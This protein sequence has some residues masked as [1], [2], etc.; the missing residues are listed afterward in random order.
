MKILVVDQGMVLCAERALYRALHQMEN[1]SVTLIAPALWKEEFGILR[2]EI[3]SSCMP[4]IASKTLFTGKSHRAIYLALPRALKEN[5][6]HILFINAEPESYLAW[7]AVVL[8]N[9]I[10]PRT[11]I[12]FVSWRNIDYRN[13]RFPYELPWFNVHAERTVLAHADH[14]VA[15]NE[16]GRGIFQ[17]KG[18]YGVT[19]IPPFVD[20]TLFR[21]T[22]DENLRKKLGLCGCVI[23]Y[24]GRFVTEKGVDVLLRAAG[25][26][27]FEYT[28]LIAGGGPAK[29]AWT[30]LAHELGIQE[31]I[32]WVGPLRHPELPHYLTCADVVV[33]P[34]KTTEYWKEQFG[35]V[36]IEAMA[37]EVPVV[38]SS[39]GEIPSVVGDAGLV[40]RE[41]DEED[42]HSKLVFL[43]SNP[44]RRRELSERGL[45]R[46]RSR[47]SIP[48]VA[49]Q[50]FL[51]FGHLL[52]DKGIS[53]SSSIK[54]MPNGE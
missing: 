21:K 34:S 22:V 54:Q 11:K 2:F 23:G 17:R 29:P 46:V 44:E 24:F 19:V 5:D 9:R 28:L 25:R 50:Y 35:R 36:L 12:V 37:C 27:D 15:H 47:F 16:T 51:L 1:I 49:H 40:F 31:K 45:K 14:C 6:F 30:R 48:I 13:G 4:V 26:F 8:R 53:K 7:Q 39:S 18:S 32:V 10:S 42:L 52:D 33:L 3:E 43:W 38:G 20:T 41:G